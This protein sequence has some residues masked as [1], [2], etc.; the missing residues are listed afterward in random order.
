MKLF[1]DIIYG[2]IPISDLALKFIDTK[3]FQRLK[4]IKQL[5]NCHFVYKSACHSRFDHSIGV[6]HLAGVYLSHIKHDFLNEKTIELIK[7]AGLCHDI[8]H[9]AFSHLF[10]HE[11][12][13]H[14]GLSKEFTHHEYRSCLLIAEMNKKYNLGFSDYQIDLIFKIIQGKKKKDIPNF[15]FQIIA[16]KDYEFDV[17]KLDYLQRDHY[18]TRFPLNLELNYIFSNCKL[19]EKE[20]IVF[21][22]KTSYK[23]ANIFMLRYKMYREVY[24]HHTVLNVDVIVRE[25]M[26][27]NIALFPDF[28]K[29]WLKYTDDYI[30]GVISYKNESDPYYDAYISRKLLTS[31]DDLKIKSYY[32]L[33]N[34]KN[35]TNPISQMLFYGKDSLPKTIQMSDIS[36]TFPNHEIKSEIIE[37]S[38][39]KLK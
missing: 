22:E 36:I 35:Y 3:E 1:L 11:I 32:G 15:V 13:P 25:M 30:L 17:D 7:I 6:Y 14:L 24:T 21:H 27:N 23:I 37:K 16:N 20:N 12:I 8:G 34:N 31:G 4:F 9:V 10:D 18:Y 5:S 19:D 39:K 2:H 26:L 38:F 33:C 28:E 29:N